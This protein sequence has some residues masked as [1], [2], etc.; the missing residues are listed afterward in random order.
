MS[1][2]LTKDLLTTET[3]TGDSPAPGT[4]GYPGSPGS[5]AWDEVIVEHGWG[6]VLAIVT[7]E[8]PIT[9]SP[10]T[11][12]YL[13]GP[14]TTTRVVHHPAI[15]ST[16]AVPAVPGM[17]GAPPSIQLNYQF[18]WNGGAQAGGNIAG[19]GMYQFSVNPSNAGI[20]TGIGPVV[21]STD[22]TRIRWALRFDANRYYVYENGVAV[23]A[24]PA[25]FIIGD[26]FTIRT[27]GGEV[28]FYINSSL[29]YRSELRSAG[30]SYVS[31]VLFA[32]GDQIIDASITN[33]TPTGFADTIGGL[34]LVEDAPRILLY[35]G[36]GIL[37]LVEPEPV[38]FAR[39]DFDLGGLILVEPRPT[40]RLFGP[41]FNPLWLVED[42]PAIHF[43]G[44]YVVPNY[45]ILTLVEDE[46]SIFLH[47]GFV[48]SLALIEPLPKFLAWNGAG[49]LQLVEPEPQIFLFNENDYNIIKADIPDIEVEMVVDVLP[50]YFAQNVIVADIPD[51]EVR[52][53][54]AGRI[55]ASI[56]EITVA[57][58]LT[59]DTG[60][61]ITAF[62]P[63]IG[64]SMPA[65][66][67]SVGT[68]DST[69]PDITVSMQGGGR[70]VAD[71]PDIEVD[72]VFSGGRVASIEASIPD[73]E[74][75]MSSIVGAALTVVAD[76]P[77][78]GQG[79]GA[80]IVAD[81]PD[82]TVYVAATAAA[83]PVLGIAYTM[84]LDNPRK[85]VT[86]YT[87]Y[88]FRDIIRYA[89]KHYGFGA[90][91]VFELTGVTDNGIGI[92]WAYKMGETGNVAG[93]GNV[94][95]FNKRTIVVYVLGSF[96]GP[97]ALT[98]KVDGG[99]ERQ[100]EK[101]APPDADV[102]TLRY[103]PGQGLLGNFWTFGQ[104]GTGPA[105]IHQLQ[106]LNRLQTRKL[107]YA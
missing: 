44:G 4:P 82:I 18:G 43:E 90:D 91:G 79:G 34:T 58:V 49:I 60:M 15:P 16:P 74:V 20:F 42:E 71:I 73:I 107:R 37:Q 36:V 45:G 105:T 57:A 30:A 28:A 70:I 35:S 24:L 8:D 68:I 19:D 13:Y 41:G 48:P 84:T 75:L 52:M 78:I 93:G 101:D 10:L 64:V 85:P 67:G 53:Y 26:V 11:T 29:I 50:V 104:F 39:D 89:G 87:N 27:L 54:G 22:Y 40:I 2:L 59:V 31:A 25:T 6:I 7:P 32:A 47:N 56:P 106:I 66:A 103:E 83:A 61:T 69:I 92:A 62:I 81:I 12:L 99:V 17:P 98:V 51:I 97:T 100:Y 21:T 88:A 94:D 96:V 1:N 76:L 102:R 38:F 46:P 33:G 23:V 55:V 80:W 65:L 77:E 63:D 86:R 5:P 9:G 72:A 95:M 3:L 14:I